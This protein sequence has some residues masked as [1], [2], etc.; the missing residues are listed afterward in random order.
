MTRLNPQ[1]GSLKIV[2]VTYASPV[3]QLLDTPETLPLNEPTTPQ[4]SFTI[5]SSHL[6][7]FSN[8]LYKVTYT[9]VVFGAGKFSTAGTLL[10][11]MKKNGASVRTGSQSVA[12]NT[13]YTVNAFFFDVKPGDVLELALWSNVS[14]SNWDYKALWI[15]FTR[16]FLFNPKNNTRLIAYLTLVFTT[17]P[18]SYPTLT[19]GSPGKNVSNYPLQVCDAEGVSAS[20]LSAGGAW[21]GKWR[22][23]HATYGVY[24]LFYHGDVSKADDAFV[25]THA[26][27]RPYHWA[28]WVCTQIKGRMLN[29]A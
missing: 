13:F 23:M 29:L 11:R 7:T 1:I 28:N 22:T 9:G 17:S 24:R 14:D 18:N 25:N 20:I 2:N 8:P 15:N 21:T 10:W 5:Q 3:E 27:Y 6:P 19:L 12:A 4:V 26:T 16:P